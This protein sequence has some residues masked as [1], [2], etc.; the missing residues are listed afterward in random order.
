MQHPDRRGQAHARFD[1][2]QTIVK[3]YSI[4]GGGLIFNDSNKVPCIISSYN[5]GYDG[6]GTRPYILENGK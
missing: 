3:P 4:N 5:K 1:N 2:S 6:F